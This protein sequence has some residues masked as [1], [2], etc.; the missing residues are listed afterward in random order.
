MRQRVLPK[1]RRVVIL[2]V[3]ASVTLAPGCAARHRATIAWFPVRAPVANAPQQVKQSAPES[4]VYKVKFATRPNAGPDDFHTYGGARRVLRRGETVGF[5]HG[6]DG[7]VHAIAGDET[8]PL[9]PRAGRKRVPA[10][11][12][13]SYRPAEHHTD[14]VGEALATA[15]KA[16]VIGAAAVGLL[17]LWLWAQSQDDDCS[18][19]SY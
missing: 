1:V 9:R 12:V 7:L 17:A 15:G 14:E 16:V 18:C 19:E 6:P 8:I 13:W 2:L 3:A 5:S 4:A 10:Y 11:L